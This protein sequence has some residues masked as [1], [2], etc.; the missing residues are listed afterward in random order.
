M[1]QRFNAPT[2]AKKQERALDFARTHRM[3]W[4]QLERVTGGDHKSQYPHA[5]EYKAVAQMAEL[6]DLWCYS[7]SALEPYHAEVG[8]VSDRT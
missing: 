6:G 5:V 2:A 8:R 4:E 1:R 7:L 3:F